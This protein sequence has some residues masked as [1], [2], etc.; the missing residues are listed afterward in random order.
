MGKKIKREEKVQREPGECLSMQVLHQGTTKR[1]R[2]KWKKEHGY[3]DIA[4]K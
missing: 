1:E 2:G 4:R 3:I